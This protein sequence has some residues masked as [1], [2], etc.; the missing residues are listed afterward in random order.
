MNLYNEYDIRLPN[1]SEWYAEGKFTAVCWKPVVW[2]RKLDKSVNN[3]ITLRVGTIFS[4]WYEF[5][6]STFIVKEGGK[7][8]NYSGGY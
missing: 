7:L 4:V 8:S 5:G 1:G 3:I 2:A 6:K